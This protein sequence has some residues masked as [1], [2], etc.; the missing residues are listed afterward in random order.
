MQSPM[1]TQ[2]IMTG[3][4][5]DTAV[6]LSEY[7]TEEEERYRICSLNAS[8]FLAGCL[9][10]VH[11]ADKFV[12]LIYFVTNAHFTRMGLGQILM[13]RMKSYI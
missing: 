12:E 13:R 10:K 9:F 5:L 1:T 3:L 2:I 8:G 11:E 7:S 4:A 6:D